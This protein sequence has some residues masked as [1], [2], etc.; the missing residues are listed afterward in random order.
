[1]CISRI[2]DMN[3]DIPLLLKQF[4]R[5]STRQLSE[6]PVVGQKWIGTLRFTTGSSKQRSGH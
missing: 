4:I 3:S 5:S 2:N 6:M 1:M